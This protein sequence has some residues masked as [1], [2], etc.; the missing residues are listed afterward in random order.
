MEWFLF[1]EI[2]KFPSMSA[3]KIFISKPCRQ[4]W[5][6]MTP[7][8]KGR[9]CSM[10]S[11]SVIDFTSKEIVEINDFIYKNKDQKICGRFNRNQVAPTFDIVV[12]DSFLYQYRGLKNAFLLSLF[13]VMGNSLFSCMNNEGHVLNKVVIQEEVK[14][15]VVKRDSVISKPSKNFPLLEVKVLEPEPVACVS[16]EP[17]PEPQIAGGIGLVEPEVVVEKK[18]S[19]Q[20]KK[21]SLK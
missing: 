14:Q 6:Q 20:V 10:C 2:F 19:L 13:V 5:D 4:N 15:E 9:F 7:D 12:Q 21:D 18:D 17:S 16:Y 3:N 11:K 1:V 8:E